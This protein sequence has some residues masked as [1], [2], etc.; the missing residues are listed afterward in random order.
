MCK[1]LRKYAERIET[2]FPH[3]ISAIVLLESIK[4][5]ERS[6]EHVTACTIA[7][8]ALLPTEKPAHYRI[9]EVF[10]PK[11]LLDRLLQPVTYGNH[12]DVN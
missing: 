1:K 8:P 7:V 9:N 2:I 10:K 6:V 11:H 12:D 4:V 5:N 3:A